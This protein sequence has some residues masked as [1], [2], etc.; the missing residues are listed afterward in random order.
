M[1]MFQTS[2]ILPSGGIDFTVMLLDVSFS[3]WDGEFDQDRR[4][5]MKMEAG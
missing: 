1:A 5:R 2:P 3:C 4:R